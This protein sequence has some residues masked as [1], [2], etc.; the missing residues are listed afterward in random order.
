VKRTLSVFLLALALGFLGLYLV[1]GR[2]VFRLETYRLP[3]ANLWLVL[4]C[5]AAFLTQWLL[6]ALRLM[7]LSKHQGHDVPYGTT[8]LIHLIASLSAALTPSGSGGGPAIAAGFA[9]AGVPWGHSIGMAIQAFVLDLVFFAWVAPLSLT[10]LIASGIIWLPMNI[11]VL[12]I[13]STALAIAA[14]II[15]G[16]YPRIAVRVFLWLAQRKLLVRFKRR[17]VMAGRD[18]YRS[19]SIFM[20]LSFSSWLF[21]Q[22]LSGLAW[23][24]SF[25]L[26]W[27]LLSLYH[28]VGFLATIAVLN[29]ISLLSFIMPTPGAS[30]F[31]EVAIG[32]GTST[33]VSSAGLAPPLLLWR[34]LSFYLI[35]AVGPVAGWLLFTRPFKPLVRRPGF[36]ARRRD[37]SG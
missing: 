12:T 34:L 28:E 19:A 7:L 37:K 16:R 30:G 33:Q 26:F 15:L 25:V 36:L 21:L 4:L 24:G 32:Y 18:Y 9:R 1:G 11:I 10:Y 14:S 29:V 3:E 8:L 35:Y 2:S 27:G 6:P 5:L 13:L 22:A 17:L 31:I 23:L 20:S